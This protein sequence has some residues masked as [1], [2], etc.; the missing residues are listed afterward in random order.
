MLQEVR[1]RRQT[2][3]VQ[4]FE[5]QGGKFKPY[6]IGSRWSLR[7]SFEDSG[8]VRDCWYKTTGADARWIH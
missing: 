1:E 7:S 5:G 2:T 4:G 3:S 6:T 8:D